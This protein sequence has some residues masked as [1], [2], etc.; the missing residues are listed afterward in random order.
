MLRFTRLSFGALL[1]LVA[2]PAF[3]EHKVAAPTK[4]Q[5]DEYKLDANFYKKSTLAQGVLIATSGRVSDL[6]HLEAAYQFEMIMKSIKPE[7]AQRIRDRR[8]LCILIGHDE[9]TS[10]LTS[11]IG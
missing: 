1:L 5:L 11:V 7:I 3:A 6:A 10:G 9:F 4:Q 2:S 8:V